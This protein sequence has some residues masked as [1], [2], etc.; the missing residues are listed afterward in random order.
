MGCSSWQRG[1]KRKD[2][3]QLPLW[4]WNICIGK[5]NAKCNAFF[6]VC[7]HLRLF[8]LRAD[9][10]KSDSSVGWEPQGNW[11]WNLNSRDVFTSSPSISR[12][13]ACRAPRRAC[14]QA[15]AGYVGTEAVSGKKKLRIQKCP[16]TCSHHVISGTF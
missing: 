3:L 16:D 9:W 6:S 15:Y 10:R 2:S 7:L 4:N 1:G 11:R 5:V 12:P 14:S 13:A 8:L